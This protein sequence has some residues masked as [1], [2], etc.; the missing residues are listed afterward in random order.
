MDLTAAAIDR[1]QQLA[2]AANHDA[3]LTKPVTLAY[4]GEL[5][6]Y[7]FETVAGPN[8]RSLGDAVQPFRPEKLTVSTLTGF[9]DA[10]NAGACGDI[11]KGKLIHV[12]DFLNVAVKNTATDHYGQRDTLLKATHTPINAFEFDKYY[13]DPQKFIIALQVAFLSTEE[14]LYLIK[15]CSALKAGSG[16]DTD[17]TG[18]NQRV[19]I[20]QG[21]VRTAD[22]EVKPRL[23][24]IPLRSFSESYESNPVESEFLLRFKQGQA[25]QPSIALFSID[26]NK[27]KGEIMR[28]IKHYLEK[29]IPGVPILA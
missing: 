20:K 16:I 14:L 24:L 25:G 18:V 12:E 6:S 3:P 2:L 13:E 1:I 23:K 17:D 26:G 7:D 9:V 21:E 11:A 10:I 27:Y 8:G 28:S 19:T 15:I 29:H 22:V 4:D 5:K